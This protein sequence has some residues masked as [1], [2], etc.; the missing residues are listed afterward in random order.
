[1][2]PDL[3]GMAG[4]GSMPAKHRFPNSVRNNPIG[5]AIQHIDGQLAHRYTE[6]SG[7]NMCE[8]GSVC[9]GRNP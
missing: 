9:A 5:S 6:V 7:D 3:H 1:M 4:L 2:L 8:Y